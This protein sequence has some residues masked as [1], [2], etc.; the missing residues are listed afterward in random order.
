[1]AQA[2]EEFGR[3]QGKIRWSVIVEQ[4]P[5][6]W[7]HY[8]YRLKLDGKAVGASREQPNGALMGQY[9]NPAD[10]TRAGREEVLRLAERMIKD[11]ASK[12]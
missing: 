2:A 12:S 1:M 3:Y 4:I 8:G 7:Q 9:A 6:D 5:G 10:A 11:G